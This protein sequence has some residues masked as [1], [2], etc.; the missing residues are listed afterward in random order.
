MMCF[1]IKICVK[2]KKELHYY[3]AAEQISRLINKT[4]CD[5]ETFRSYHTESKAYKFYCFDLP[6]PMLI[7][8]KYKA[9]DIHTLRIRTVKAELA[10]YFYEQLRYAETEYL[11]VLNTEIRIISKKTIETIYSLTPL[12]IKTKNGYWRDSM[13]VA[14]FEER[15][16]VNA[17]KKYRAVTGDLVDENFELYTHLKF[18]NKKPIKMQ[19]KGITLLGDKI[20][21]TAGK[22]KMAQ[23]MLYMSI[24]T[25]LLENNS[26]GA[27][28]VGYRYL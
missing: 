21:I 8:G 5:N 27:G 22:N 18:L 12:I 25:G 6:F 17:I 1:E 28:T 20:Q 4:L 26:T 3:M 10:E 14:E 19:Y 7:N 16:K 13:S 23:E 15:L 2:V 24:G 11:K 9:D